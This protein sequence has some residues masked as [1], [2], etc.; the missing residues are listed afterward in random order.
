MSMCMFMYAGV[1]TYSFMW[2][3]ACSCVS[4]M[5]VQAGVCLYVKNPPPLS[6]RA[7]AQWH[8]DQAMI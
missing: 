2:T 4:I 1:R 5:L 7:R 3:H 6:T 8:E